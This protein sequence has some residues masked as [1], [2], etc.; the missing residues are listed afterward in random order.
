MGLQTGFRPGE[1]PPHSPPARPSRTMVCLSR[2]GSGRCATPLMASGPCFRAHNS[3]VECHL[4]TVEVVGSNPAAP[5]NPPKISQAR[6]F[7]WDELGARRGPRGHNAQNGWSFAGWFFASVGKPNSAATRHRATRFCRRWPARTSSGSASGIPAQ[8]VQP[9]PALKAGHGIS[10]AQVHIARDGIRIQA[11]EDP[12][13]RQKA[14]RS[15]KRPRPGSGNTRPQPRKRPR[16][17]R[18]YDLCR[19]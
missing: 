19:Q 11:L 1:A 2:P 14:P 16:N 3:A 13:P 5:T 7:R 10:P 9:D 15:C 12:S 17:A 4:H 18:H 6:Q 8:C